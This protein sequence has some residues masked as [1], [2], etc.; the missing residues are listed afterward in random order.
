M[1]EGVEFCKNSNYVLTG[2]G[3]SIVRHD[4]RA[5]KEPEVVY[6]NENG[7]EKFTFKYMSN[8]RLLVFTPEKIVVVDLAN[9]NNQMMEVSK[10]DLECDAIYAENEDNGQTMFHSYFFDDEKYLIMVLDKTIHRLDLTA[11]DDG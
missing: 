4:L 10:D 2:Q 8:D 1:A 6:E 7:E 9:D 11:I 3:S 5:S